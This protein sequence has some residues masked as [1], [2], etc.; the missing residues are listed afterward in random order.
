MIKNSFWTIS[1]YR[2]FKFFNSPFYNFKI[3]Q[4]LP[5]SFHGYLY[6]SLMD[7][8]AIA[9]TILVVL[10]FAQQLH[11]YGEKAE[12]GVSVKKSDEC[13][14]FQGSW[15]YDESYPLY[16][17]SNCPFIEKQFDCL[18]NGRPDK[19]YLKYRWQPTACSN[20]TRFDG[21]DFL[22]R[23]RGKSIMYVGDS[24]SLN[25]W[26]SL[27]CMLH[28]AVPNAKYTTITVQ[29]LSTF[30]FPEYNAKVMF[31]RNAFL[32]DLV[33]MPIG[34]VLKLDSIEGAQLWKGIDVLIFN[35]WHW[36]LHTGRKQPYVRICMYISLSNF[37]CM[38]FF[39]FWFFVL[40]MGFHCRRK[41][42]AAG[43]GSLG[44]V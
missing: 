6:L 32:V 29:G 16:E 5:L 10:C 8:V 42:Y 24:L 23:I 31:S 12:R 11:G 4:I 18:K 14:V 26:Q 41:P 2:T 15:V 20:L 22:S 25:Q 3:P 21:K 9:A 35:T 19:H 39:F 1:I 17:T 13:D 38:I 43:H 30:T 33:S 44:C 36:W 34:R 27:T 40:Q 28:S 37:I 7:T